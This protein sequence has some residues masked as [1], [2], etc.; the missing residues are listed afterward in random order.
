MNLNC[1]YQHLINGLPEQNLHIFQ[2]L[3]VIILTL[4]LYIQKC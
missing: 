1:F 3:V 2:P 4:Q